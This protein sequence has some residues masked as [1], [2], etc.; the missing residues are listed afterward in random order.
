MATI[1]KNISVSLIFF[2]IF[3]E[4]YRVIYYALV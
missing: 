3:V 4:Y 1:I 2:S